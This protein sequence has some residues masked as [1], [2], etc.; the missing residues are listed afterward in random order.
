MNG[1]VLFQHS[2]NHV[3]KGA[4]IKGKNVLPTGSTFFPL[5][6]APLRVD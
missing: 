4:T 5:K 6:E 2:E 1:R 3:L